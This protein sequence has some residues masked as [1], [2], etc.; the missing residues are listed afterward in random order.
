[1]LQKHLYY[2]PMSWPAQTLHTSYPSSTAS[3]PEGVIHSR[4]KSWC[5]GWGAW[6]LV[7]MAYRRWWSH[8][9]I[10]WAHPSYPHHHWMGALHCP[11][12]HLGGPAAATRDTT[13][14][15][16]FLCLLCVRGRM[17][18]V[19]KYPS[20]EHWHLQGAGRSPLTIRCGSQEL[21]RQAK[22]GLHH[23][24][25]RTFLDIIGNWIKA[26]N[27]KSI[28]ETFWTDASFCQTHRKRVYKA[29]SDH[30][31]ESS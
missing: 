12:M 22:T 4:S 8:L 6:S 26:T 11:G 31:M 29:W 5:L 25:Q 24:F 14:G 13:L 19:D 21:S 20:S 23:R 9:L 3:F 17:A 16:S 2:E 10:F 18:K 30:K 28:E 7:C 27:L 15:L 1:M